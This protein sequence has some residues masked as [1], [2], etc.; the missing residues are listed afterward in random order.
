[1]A[2]PA[3]I[4]MITTAVSTAVSVAGSIAQGQ[5]QSKQASFQAEIARKQGELTEMQSRSQAADIE[6]EAQ[7]SRAQQITQAAAAGLDIYDSDSLWDVI[8]ASQK[9]AESERQGILRAGNLN[10]ASYGLEAQQYQSA[11]KTARSSSWI[12]AGTSLLK[13]TAQGISI[14]DKAGWFD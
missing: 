1:M 8:N 3:T 14:A 11:S 13:G 12:N 4:A 10:K 2:D 5:T 6:L 7:R 9:E